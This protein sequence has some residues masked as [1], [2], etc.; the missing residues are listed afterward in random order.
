MSLGS[1][2]RDLVLVRSTLE[3]EPAQAV[4]QLEHAWRIGEFAALPLLLDHA[5]SIAPDPASVGPDLRGWLLE[6]G[7]NIYRDAESLMAL[8]WTST[9]IREATADDARARRIA[10]NGRKTRAHVLQL[11]GFLDAA[12]DELEAADAE[13][14]GVDREIGDYQIINAD[15]QIRSAALAAVAGDIAVARE[16]LDAINDEAPDQMRLGAQRYRLHAESMAIARSRQRRSFSPVRA[17]RYEQ[18]LA[19]IDNVLPSVPVDRQ[20]TVIDTVIGAALRVGDVGA[21]RA[22]VDRVDWAKAAA[23]PNIEFRLAG[24]LRQA[25]NLPSLEDLGD[26]H[27]RSEDHPLRQAGMV[28]REL[29]FLL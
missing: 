3:S 27:L 4:G 20:L 13:F 5:L 26:I 23:Q 21:I 29:K 11:H 14:S 28:P 12:R 19:E 22:V 2:R 18:A 6:V 7:V 24:R 17:A 8:T 10:A 9:W 16:L 25:S 15:L 1:T